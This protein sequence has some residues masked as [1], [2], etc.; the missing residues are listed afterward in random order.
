MA[1]N[2]AVP[3]FTGDKTI[4]FNGGFNDDGTLV[5]KQDQALP[6]TLLA[7]FPSIAVYDK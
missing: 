1:Q 5:I 3:M 2:E 7:V 4:E 6:M